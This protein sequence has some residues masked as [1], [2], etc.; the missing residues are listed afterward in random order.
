MAGSHRSSATATGLVDGSVSRATR[1]SVRTVRLLTTVFAWLGAAALAGN[2]LF[3]GAGIVRFPLA[4]VVVLVA[5]TWLWWPRHDGWAVAVA[6][7][8]VTAGAAVVL[9]NAQPVLA[10]LFGT[11]TRRA[12]HG[13]PRRYPV[14]SLV[15]LGGYV[16]GLGVSLSRLDRVDPDVVMAAVMPLLGLVIGTFALHETVRAVRA[17]QAARRTVGAVLQASPVGLAVLDERGIPRLHNLRAREMFGW[18]DDVEANAVLCPHGVGITRCRDGCAAGAVEV[19]PRDGVVLSVHTG[20]VEQDAGPDH[21]VV[22]AVDVSRRREWERA[23]RDR[24][25]RDELTGLA[26]RAHFLHLVREAMDAEPDVGLLVVDLDRFKDVNDA[27]GHEVG[28]RYLQAS[29]ARVRSALPPKAVAGRLGGDEF[30]VLAPGFG[31]RDTV[32]LAKSVLASL[33]GAVQPF[34]ASVGAAVSQAGAGVADLLRDADTA[35][36]V[37]KRDGGNRVRM[38]R[39]EMG[40]QALA[41]QRDRAD[42]RTAI[43][44]GELVVHYQPIVDL[45]TSAVTGAEALVRWQRPGVGLLG[46]DAFI[47]LAEETGLIVPLGEKV[48]Q[49]ASEQAVRWHAEGR[50]LGVTVNVS[51]RELATPGF[52]PRLERVITTAGL[53]PSR[54]TVEVTESVWADEPAM[55]TLVSVRDAGIRVA[56]DDFGTGYSSLSYLQR[57]PFD[58]VKIDRSFTGALGRNGRTEGVIRCIIALA[59]VLGAK[60]VA[61]GIET[62]DQ[63][64]WLRAAGCS[65]AQG[66]LFGRPADAASWNAHSS[67][68]FPGW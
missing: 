51:T 2:L 55:R 18:D 38:F 8:V 66:Y 25:E 15:S 40:E 4:A 31:V 39:Q 47:G 17:Q 29:A 44:G 62:P 46:P 64:D 27:D 22:A 41:R 63:A 12:L 37:A 45:A 61:E 14:R 16:G 60:T 49:A 23:L 65:Y 43:E 1:A 56:L 53:A 6:E 20:P 10:F 57:Y 58:V 7:G 5:G 9:P 36:Y 28:D 50:C 21:V 11:T 52:L 32:R 35:M 30:A 59:D 68:A 33:N 13:G 19:E 54:L 24:A 34:A 3:A 67:A 26:S 48:L 42:L